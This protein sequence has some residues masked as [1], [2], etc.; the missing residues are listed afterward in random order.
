MQTLSC[1]EGDTVAI[2][3]NITVR[4]LAIEG[5]DVIL[6]VDAPD[7]MELDYGDLVGALQLA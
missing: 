7:G 1:R 5:G 3:D 4:V 6:E 2:G